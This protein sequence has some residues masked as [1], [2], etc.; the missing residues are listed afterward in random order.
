MIAWFR[1]KAAEFNQIAD[2]LESTF[3][4][5]RDG[6]SLQPVVQPAEVTLDQVKGLMGSNNVRPADLAKMLRTSKAR[7]EEIIAAHPETFEK[8]GKGWL[9]LK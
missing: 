5:D 3:S 8:Y 9:R 6:L 2:N 1:A 7:V 4:G